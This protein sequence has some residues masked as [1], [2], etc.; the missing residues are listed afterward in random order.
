MNSDT[1]PLP[2]TGSEGAPAWVVTFSDLMS[3]L[4]CFFVLMLS[5]SELDRAKYK[6]VAGSLAKAFGVQRVQKAFQVPK[7]VTMIAKDFD[8]QPVPLHAREEFVAMQRRQEAGLELK[9]A[10][11]ER[12]RDLKDLIQVE[13][14]RSEVAI[15]LMGET[16]FDSGKAEIRPQMIPLLRKISQVLEGAPGDIVIAGHTDNVPVLGGLYGSNLQLSTARSATVAEFLMQNSNIA[17]QRIAT[18]GFGQYRPI[19]SNET[20][21]GRRRNRRVEIV[22]R[23]PEKLLQSKNNG[24]GVIPQFPPNPKNNPFLK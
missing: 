1:N 7:G 2:S 21:E 23:E 17:P 11:E 8:Q 15:R 19:D 10:V 13:I 18:M 22:L 24:G 5:F 14:N 9:K 12:F 6:E 3:L 4:L 20:N 16:A